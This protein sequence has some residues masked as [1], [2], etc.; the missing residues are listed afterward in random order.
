MGFRPALL[1]KPGAYITLAKQ[2]MT[3]LDQGVF[4]TLLGALIG[5]ALGPAVE[6]VSRIWT[7]NGE[8]VFCVRNGLALLASANAFWA[9]VFLLKSFSGFDDGSPISAGVFLLIYAFA[10]VLFVFSIVQ[11]YKSS[12]PPRLAE[13]G[14]LLIWLVVGNSMWL[15][16]DLLYALQLSLSFQRVFL[17]LGMIALFIPIVTLLRQRV[18]DQPPA[19]VRPAPRPD[20]RPRFRRRR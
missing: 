10:T 4:F 20:P 1:I 6:I 15:F 9:L 19:A 18:T 7:R 13:V 12:R 11:F 5:A 3:D 17:G 8:A 2:R 14:G 16:S